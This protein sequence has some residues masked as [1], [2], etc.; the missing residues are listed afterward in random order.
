MAF[1][2]LTRQVMTSKDPC[3]DPIRAMQ[4]KC[5]T[6]WQSCCNERSMD[7]SR[8]VPFKYTWPLYDNRIH[9][10]DSFV[11]HY[12]SSMSRGS[13]VTPPYNPE[14]QMSR[15]RREAI[16]SLLFELYRNLSLLYIAHT[17]HNVFYA[18]FVKIDP[19]M[20]KQINFD[21]KC[22]SYVIGPQLRRYDIEFE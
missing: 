12:T 7:V 9:E 15:S 20:R 2:E 8:A 18:I 16:L 11:L 17:V 6:Q 3:Q 21:K 4:E 22:I 19:S 1:R 13:T 14:N 10:N 5:N